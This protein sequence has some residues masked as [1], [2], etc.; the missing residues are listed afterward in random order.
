MA[1][2]KLFPNLLEAIEKSQDALVAE[3]MA[4]LG[5][6]DLFASALKKPASDGQEGR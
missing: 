5:E 4:A 2:I 3:I 1:S 6:Y